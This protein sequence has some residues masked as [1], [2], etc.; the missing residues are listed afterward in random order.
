MVSSH[1][2]YVFTGGMIASFEKSLVAY[3]ADAHGALVVTQE[4]SRLQYY[5]RYGYGRPE[6][7]MF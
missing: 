4:R 1:G 6:L 2:I 5:H 7:S 3:T